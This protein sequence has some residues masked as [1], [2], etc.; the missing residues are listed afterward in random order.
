MLLRA[1]VPAQHLNSESKE[2]IKLGVGLVGTMAALLLGLLVASAKD[3][4]DTRR[5]E[6]TQLATN[7]I[8]LDR[9]LAH[10]GP[11]TA[12]V[13]QLLKVAI[14]R[15]VQQ[16]WE[17]NVNSQSAQ[18]G[19]GEV[20]FEKIQDLAPHA[21]AQRA[22]QSEAESMA[23]AHGQTR[24]LIF[25]QSGS[26]ISLPFFVFIVFWLSILFVAFG[27]LAHW[28]TTLAITLLVSAISVAGAIFL[29]LELDHSFSGLIQISRR[30]FAM[31]SESLDT[32]PKPRR[33]KVYAGDWLVE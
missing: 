26:S 7:T 11:E 16:K 19:G 32:K 1:A 3:S 28:N 6:I 30:P 29:I 14:T 18:L 24:W 25:E 2:V 10:Y 15:V 31:R 17:D 12:S 13:R 4:Y 27:L 20:V 33:C 23:I 5:S 21:D 8:L 9:V 22:M